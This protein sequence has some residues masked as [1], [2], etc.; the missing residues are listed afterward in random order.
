MDV[1]FTFL[2]DN[3]SVI[4][5][6]V[7]NHGR[8]H[9]SQLAHCGMFE[10]SLKHEGSQ[11]ETVMVPASRLC[12]AMYFESTYEMRTND[13]EAVFVAFHEIR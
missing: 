9:G 3:E 13:N 8:L 2:I 10:F 1:T 7:R 4:T 5:F 11:P 6:V 12:N